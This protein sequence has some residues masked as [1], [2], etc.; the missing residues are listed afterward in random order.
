MLADLLSIGGDVATWLCLVSLGI[1]GV[2]GAV[3]FDPVRAAKASD[4]SAQTPDGCLPCIG[5]LDIVH[6]CDFIAAV[7]LDDGADH[8][9]VGIL[10][11]SLQ[12]S[13]HNVHGVSM[14]STYERLV[15]WEI[16]ELRNEFSDASFGIGHV[17][18]LS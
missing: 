2:V 7:V 3:L 4:W 11:L 17:I 13:F 15:L 10:M 6:S 1:V 5:W 8:V 12:M 9:A 14:L 18:L 16:H